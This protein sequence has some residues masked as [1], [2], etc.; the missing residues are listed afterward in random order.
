MSLTLLRPSS[1]AFLCVLSSYA[2]SNRSSSLHLETIAFASAC[3]SHALRSLGL[4]SCPCPGTSRCQGGVPACAGSRQSWNG[5]VS[6]SIH[7]EAQGPC[8]LSAGAHSNRP[9]Q[10]TRSSQTSCP[11][12]TRQGP[13]QAQVD[14]RGACPSGVNWTIDLPGA[15]TRSACFPSSDREIY[16]LSIQD[17][18]FWRTS[19]RSSLRPAGMPRYPFRI[20]PLLPGHLLT[21]PHVCQIIAPAAHDGI[22]LP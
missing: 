1:L 5:Q 2:F 19:G 10:A 21:A 8:R 12:K 11:G 15:A 14:R 20:A 4:A 9:G 16:T 22:G 7:W 18:R 17:G 13:S 3:P 6:C